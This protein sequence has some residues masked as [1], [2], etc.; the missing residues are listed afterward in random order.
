[1]KPGITLAMIVKDEE[2]KLP[3][4]LAS[5]E[6]VVDDIVV[7]DTGSTDGTLEIARRHGARVFQMEWPG[8]FDAARNESLRHV[9]TEWILWLD[10]DEWLEKGSGPKIRKVIEWDDA[11]CFGLVIREVGPD[12]VE[13]CATRLWRSRPSVPF[14]GAIHEHLDPSVLQ[15]HG[16]TRKEFATDIVVL[17][18]GY[19]PGQ[20]QAKQ[21]R[22][23]ELLK[24]E[25]ELRPGQPYYEVKLACTL[26]AVGHPDARQEL[27]RIGDRLLELQDEMQV[28]PAYAS[29]F[30]P[31]FAALADEELWSA[32]VDTL[33]R[34]AGGWFPESPAVLWQVAQVEVRRGN[35][36]SALYALME[37]EKM[38]ES[39]SFDRRTPYHP[40]ILGLALWTNLALVAHQVG[41]RDV[42]LRNYRR[43]LEV[44]PNNET[45]KQNMAKLQP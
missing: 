39:G 31:L 8:A 45:A 18:D 27:L 44:D 36:P 40:G 16:E 21:A 28:D 13:F 43:I 5:V 29:V 11:Y 15:A 26:A 19:S 41:R 3:R 14:V 17:H 38:A 33:I 2:E 25:L 24:K 30:G 32:P 7:V 34:L 6:G 22:S 20:R 35:L 9:E 37:I 12:P 10:A 23:I 4:C 42:A 1:M